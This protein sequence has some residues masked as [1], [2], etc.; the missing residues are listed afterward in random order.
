V[1]A[2]GDGLLSLA[3]RKDTLISYIA[4]VRVKEE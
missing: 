2:G 1:I 4:I 3:F